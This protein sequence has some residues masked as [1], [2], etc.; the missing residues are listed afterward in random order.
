MKSSNP[1]TIEFSIYNAGDDLHEISSFSD[2]IKIIIK[3]GDP[4]GNPDEFEEAIRKFLQ[5][6]YDST[7]ISNHR[8]FFRLT[9]FKEK[10]EDILTIMEKA[11]QLLNQARD[12]LAK[13]GIDQAGDRLTSLNIREN[14]A[15][16][17][18]ISKFLPSLSNKCEKIK[19]QRSTVMKS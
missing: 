14:I 12:R 5:E 10:E 6:W 1:K 13:W 7:C 4:R 16:G 2:N 8:W 9:S 18:S 17:K 19:S 11:Y 15:I 3:S